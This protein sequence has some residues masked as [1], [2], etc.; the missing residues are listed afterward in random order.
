MINVSHLTT[1]YTGEARYIG[2]LNESTR[3]HQLI[4]IYLYFTIN[5][6]ENKEELI[7]PRRCPN[8]LKVALI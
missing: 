4:S 2:H 8:S 1:T 5:I 3:T 7:R 6:I